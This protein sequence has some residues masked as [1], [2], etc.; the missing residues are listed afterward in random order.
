MQIQ[1]G[2]GKSV[3]LAENIA[4]SFRGNKVSVNIGD[5]RRVLP[6][7]V[8]QTLKENTIEIPRNELIGSTELETFPYEVK[9]ENGGLRIGPVIAFVVKKKMKNL[10]QSVL[11]EYMEYFSNY[12][13]IKGLVYICA[14]DSFDISRQKVTGYAFKPH[15]KDSFQYGIYPIP[16]VIYRRTK[17]DK[18][19][20]KFINDS[21]NAKV[22]NEYVF[23]KW[24]LYSLL[25]S[26]VDIL[27]H[28]PNTR[29][30]QSTD[31]LQTMLNS[32]Q[33]VFVKPVK[34]S[35]GKGII[36]VKKVGNNF[37]FDFPLMEDS[38]K[39][40]K[41]LFRNTQEKKM[42]L[43]KLKSQKYILYRK[44]MSVQESREII[45]LL[46]KRDYI[47]QQAVH[48]KKA[49][50]RCIDFRVIMQKDYHCKWNCNG[51]IARIGKKNS[52][53]S[54]FTLD[55]YA[56]NGY[57][58]LIRLF[59]MT[60]EEA[61][62]KVQ[63]VIQLCQD[64]CLELERKYIY[65]DLGFDVSIDEQ[66]NIWILEVNKFHFHDY[67]IFALHDKK[68]YEK[69]VAAPLSYAKALARF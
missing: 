9:I 20:L 26:R 7:K 57:E 56:L 34:G 58:A 4:T 67:P 64:T 24:E 27:K 65:G 18:R 62:E 60:N 15:H 5:F 23:N 40:I 19:T 63:E 2:T 14:A 39:F 36:K 16:D 55:G 59:G 46:K 44:Q 52:V 30:L 10:T 8:N 28:L 37:R 21:T 33:Q 12:D 68:M 42:L 54:N 51:I 47:I 53:I 61:K 22:F 45:N 69:V 48:M 1:W 13:Q 41:Y 66:D 11:K 25:K 3:N 50:N 31:D 6:V 43:K 32:Y 17:L 29:R 49:D 35:L 38:T